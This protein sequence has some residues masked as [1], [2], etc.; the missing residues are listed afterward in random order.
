MKKKILYIITFFICLNVYSSEVSGNVYLDNNSNF[1]NIKI[2][3]SPVSPSAVFKEIYSKNDGSFTTQVDNGIYNIIYSKDQYQNLQINNVFVSTDV[4]LD[5]ATLSS[6]LLIEISGNVEGNWTKENT[7]KIVGNATVAVGKVLTIEEG[8]E[9]KFAGKYSLIINGKLFANGKT[10]SYIK[11]SSFKN[12]PTKDDWNQVVVDQG[13]EA[14][15][16]YSIIEYGKENSDWNGMLQI[17]GK[18]E[19]T[20]SIIRETNGTAIGASSSEN[21][22][23]SNNEIYNSDW[24][25]IVAGSGVFNIFN[26]KI[27]NTRLGGILDRSDTKNTTL[28]NNILGN[29]GQECIGSLE[30]ILL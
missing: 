6:N 5:N 18:A 7:Y 26:N 1:E 15:F 13:G 16:N 21:V 3:F 25:S 19:I 14:M 10:G 2:T 4:I 8:T 22:I 30:I 9:I 28:K 29:C 11:F 12:P 20:N 23:I 24:A 17:R 27:S